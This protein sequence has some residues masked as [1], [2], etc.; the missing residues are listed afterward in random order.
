MTLNETE[1][2]DG[3]AL[4]NKVSFPLNAQ[5]YPYYSSTY[6]ASDATSI[7]LSRYPKVG[8]ARKV[9][10][11]VLAFQA[12][13]VSQLS[14]YLNKDDVRRRIDAL[15]AAKSSKVFLDPNLFSISSA[16]RWTS[17]NPKSA[18]NFGMALDFYWPEL[19]SDSSVINPQQPSML[20]SKL[21]DSGG[22]FISLLIAATKIIPD[23][24]L[25]GRRHIHVGFATW[26]NFQIS[27]EATA[28]NATREVCL[29]SGSLIFSPRCLGGW[30]KDGHYSYALKSIWTIDTL[31]VPSLVPNGR[32]T[33]NYSAKNNSS[34]FPTV[35]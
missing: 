6:P 16:Y 14:D 32:L 30:E 1:W 4:G 5:N 15:K 8:D 3:L 35:K 22:F 18:H 34:L 2:I 33:W 11:L 23:Q 24:V 29:Q 13:V 7:I 12:S 26:N 20:Q 28:N 10:A 31:L 25:L 19:P 21:R 17:T 9:V 27:V